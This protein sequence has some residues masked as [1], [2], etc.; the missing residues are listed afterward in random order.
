[1]WFLIAK[2]N[3]WELGIAV[4]A[5]IGFFS[6]II[7]FIIGLLILAAPTDNKRFIATFEATRTTISEQRESSNSELERV[8]LT[9]QIIEMNQELAERKYYATSL[10]CNW[11]TS[12][13]VLK[14]EPLK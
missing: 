9:K 10:W 14:I 1:M 6:I 8:E 2:I 3:D 4:S 12:T 5:G 11:F 13:D 7:L